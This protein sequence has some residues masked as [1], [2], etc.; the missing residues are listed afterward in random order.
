ML[1]T[2]EITYS[3]T[4]QDFTRNFNKIKNITSVYLTP[5]DFTCD[6]TDLEDIDAMFNHMVDGNLFPL[7]EVYSLENQS[8]EPTYTESLQDSSHKTYPGKDIYKLKF[9]WR[10]D[11]HQLISQFN[12]KKLRVIFGIQNRY[13]L[14]VADGDN[15]KGFLLSGISLQDIELFGSNMSPLRLELGNKTERASEL[16]TLAG[17][18]INEIDRRILEVTTTATANQMIVGVTFL[19]TVIETLITTDF[20]VTD[21]EYGELTFN[22]FNYNGGVYDLQTF[23]SDVTPV[24]LTSGC[25]QITS[26][27][28]IG[29]QRYL[30]EAVSTYANFV[31]QSSDNFVLQSGDNLTMI[32]TI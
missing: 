20:T 24:S 1:I 29:K 26:E 3:N 4:G 31:L 13:F 11:Y 16:L 12:G 19:G 14:S 23:F 7:H 25:V 27:A 21:D 5:E 6:S 32:N 9:N 30:V 22:Y 8:K 15:I 2:P 10:L 28:Y 18:R 17:Y